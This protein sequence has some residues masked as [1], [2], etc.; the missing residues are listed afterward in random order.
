MKKLVLRSGP[1]LI[2]FLFV[3]WLVAAPVTAAAADVPGPDA[4]KGRAAT[5]PLTFLG[6]QDDE[7]GAGTPA[8]FSKFSLKL[9]GGYNH[10]LAGDVNNGSDFYFEFLEAYAAEFG[11]TVTGTYKPVHGGLSFGGDL[12]Y[13]ITP[14]L[15]IGV[16]AGYM[17]S[18]SD[19]LGTLT[20]EG[21]SV[22]L[23]TNVILSAVPIRLGLFLDVPL[24]GKLVLT[25]NAGAAYY[26]GLKFDGT[27]RLENNLGSWENR[28]AAGTKRS[29]VDIGFHGSLGFE[30]KLSSKLGFFVEAVGRY[31]KFKNFETVT[32]T[33]ESSLG[34]AP[35]VTEGVLYLVTDTIFT[36]EITGFT[37][38]E[39]TPM[40]D[41]GETYREPKFDLGGFSL[42]AGLRIRL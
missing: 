6:L 17:R 14:S 7:A 38:E 4:G 3:A 13:Q 26:A 15:G 22:D 36:T 19:S 8:A 32:G 23:T 31:A 21:Q 30:Y 28:N 42:Q 41:P 40:P 39:S 9:Y 2:G 24:G 33:V 10:M 29:G 35:N 20:F 27:E 12:I 16:G 5:K 1:F 37:I 34:G 25:A 11:G 18:S